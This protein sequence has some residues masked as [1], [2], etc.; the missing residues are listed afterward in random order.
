MPSRI[1]HRSMAQL[2]VFALIVAPAAA[3]AGGDE[4]GNGDRPPPE[5]RRSAATGAFLPFTMSARSDAQRALVHMQGGYDGARDGVVFGSVVEAQ[6]LG[7]VSLRA[8]G[9]YLGP[10][11][12]LRPDVGFKLDALRQ[13]RHGLNL[14]VAG[15]YEAQGFN[16]TPAISARVAAARAF[17]GTTLF[18]NV[19]YGKA[20]EAGEHYGDARV[21][22]LQQVGRDL[23]LG[24]DSRYR[25]DLERDLDEPA[26]EPDW[27]LVAGPLASYALGRF[28]VSA[29][30][31]LSALKLRLS[32]E[33]QVGVQGTMGLG[34]VF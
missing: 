7:P 26:G 4:G 18:G 17:G 2:T 6:L 19:A 23:H 13:E 32:D 31:G 12:R 5:A 34:A 29:G 11:G 9:S 25:V 22:V 16:M 33:R 15:G 10:T 21:A 3:R 30:A 24:V 20:T 8:G 1:V 28:V 27:E 14:A